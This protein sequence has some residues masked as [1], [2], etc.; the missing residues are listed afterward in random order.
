MPYLVLPIRI[1]ISNKN[2]RYDDAVD[3]AGWRVADTVV[4]NIGGTTHGTDTGIDGAFTAALIVI[5]RMTAVL[6]YL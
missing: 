6:L 2:L 1:D 3:R 4:T 5:C